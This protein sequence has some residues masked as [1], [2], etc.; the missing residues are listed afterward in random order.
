MNKR[1]W[2][3][4]LLALVL[5]IGATVGSAYAYFTTYSTAK[6]GYII[7]MGN[8]TEIEEKALG[9]KKDITIRNKSE[10]DYPVFVRVK[11]FAG[12]EITVT[13]VFSNEYWEKKTENGQDVYYFLNTLEPGKT[14]NEDGNGLLTF[15]LSIPD[16]KEVDVKE[17]DD[18]K[19]ILHG[20][21]IVVK[22]WKV[23]ELRGL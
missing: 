23:I 13:P 16:P 2:F 18:F 10:S 5:V 11:V 14:T 15:N 22:D 8:E 3:L 17:G 19:K 6:G 20:A 21:E 12:S 1:K 7:H 4:L 9:S